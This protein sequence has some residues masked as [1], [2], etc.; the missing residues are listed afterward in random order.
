MYVSKVA[1]TNQV[2]LYD[3]Q[4]Q[5]NYLASHSYGSSGGAYGASD[6]PEISS[7]GRF[8]A[9]RS[10]ASDIAPGATNNAPNLFLCDRSNGSTT[11][12]SVN[13]FGT[14]A[15]DNRS[16]TPVFSGDAQTLVFESWASDL[17]AQ[18]FNHSSDIFACHLYS[19]GEIPLFSLAI[20]PG[21]GPGQGPS[22]CWPVVRGRS[23]CVQ[24]KNNLQDPGWQTPG[25]NV[26]VLGNQAFFND[27]SA[28]PSPRFYR[29]VGY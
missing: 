21:T 26:T 16:S 2:Y 24:F 11:L 8:I 18:D 15:G 25:G 27:L 10:T 6:W 4:V 9:Y 3:L 13:R 5:T 23:Y 19:S 17:V 22:L 7:D 14:A 1:A 20:L 29:V 28:G 12:L